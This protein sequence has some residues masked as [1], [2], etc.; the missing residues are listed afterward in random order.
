MKAKRNSHKPTSIKEDWFTEWTSSSMVSSSSP[1][2][3]QEENEKES[4]LRLNDIMLKYPLKVHKRSADQK[5]KMVLEGDHDPRDEEIIASFR[6]MLF[7][8]G[9][10]PQEHNDYHTLIRFL[11]RMNFDLIKAK[12][13]FLEYLKWREDFH[14]DSITKEF[15][16][17]EYKDVKRCYPHGFHGVDR[18]GRPL[19]IER[20]GMVDL[21]VFLQTTSI[22]RFV[23]Y[24]VSEQEK[25]LKSRFPACSISAEKHIASTTSILDVKNVGVSNF[26]KPARYLFM[27]IQKIDS[28]YYPETLHCLYII[29]AGPGFRVLWNT[30]KAFLEP[31][32]L[33]KI[34][35]LGTNYKNDFIEAIDP[36]NLPSFFGGNCEC[37]DYGGCLLSDKG[38]WNNPEIMDMLQEM[39]DSGDESGASNNK[40]SESDMDDIVIEDVN[41]ITN[42][43]ENRE[44]ENKLSSMK[45]R[46]LE[47]VL[48]ESSMIFQKLEVALNDAKLVL[49]TLAQNIE[50][51]KRSNH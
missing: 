28:N 51:L 50:Q 13:S 30:L 19:Y 35:V 34:R 10:L 49:Q 39:T 48:N 22:D 2:P 29:N 44:D 47:A 5:F 16:Y 45:L 37:L 20:I 12:Y 40:V 38:P 7:L 11:R 15:K 25:T 26:S 41:D 36:S 4:I 27:E 24:H 18:H 17:E 9:L 43:T 8:D 32:T 6:Q 46:S 1:S 3:Q 33:A 14:V 42:P 23:K 31:R 21:N